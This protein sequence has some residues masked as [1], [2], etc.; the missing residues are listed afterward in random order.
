MDRNLEE[1]LVKWREKKNSKPLIL[2]GARQV[3]KTY[4]IDEFGKKYFKNY[5]KINCEY[6]LEYLNFFENFQIKKLLEALSV[7][8]N[9]DIKQGETLI[10]IDEIQDCPKALQALRYF[11]E[12]YPGL[13]II[14]A[15]SLLE[16]ILNSTNFK[17]PVGR[18]SF[19][20]LHPMS[21]DEFLQARD[22]K[23]LINYLSELNLKSEFNQVIHDTLLEELRLYYLV[24]GMPEAVKKFIEHENQD[25]DGG[26][27]EAFSV[28]REILQAY[29]SDFGKYA[30][31][32]R[33]NDLDSVLNYVP[34]VLGHKFKYSKVYPEAR[35]ENIR[36][37]FFLLNQAGLIKRIIKTQGGLPLGVQINEKH[38]KAILLDLGLATSILDLKSTELFGKRFWDRIKGGISEQYVGQELLCVR[39]PAEEP[40]LYF[41][42]RDSHQSSAELDY[43]VNH[44]NQII[45]IEVKSSA[46]GKLKSLK[47]FMEKHS[48]S[49]GIKISEAELDYDPDSKILSLPLYAVQEIERIIDEIRH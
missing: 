45:P 46:N 26:L 19:M 6:D 34:Q 23:T 4:L 12:E 44:K 33:I 28:H 11:Y 10:F 37:S 30:K 41:W 8:K 9:V 2:R 36:E 7:T 38:F 22:K 15:G 18:V 29:K 40:K 3:G 39:D 16:F 21:F 17:F 47:I 48:L 42:E 13:H 35:S 43:I 1:S 14:A 31:K 5:V 20:Y 49:L 24:G 27:K 32:S 25:I